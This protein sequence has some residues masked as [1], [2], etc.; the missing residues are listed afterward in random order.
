MDH[1]VWNILYADNQDL[2]FFPIVLWTK[3]SLVIFTKSSPSWFRCLEVGS[4]RKSIDFVNFLTRLSTRYFQLLYLSPELDNVGAAFFIIPGILNKNSC[5][6]HFGTVWGAASRWIVIS[7][8][9]SRLSNDS[10]GEWGIE[11]S[12]VWK[13]KWC[14]TAPALQWFLNKGGASWGICRGPEPSGQASLTET[15]RSSRPWYGSKGLLSRK[16]TSGLSSGRGAR[17]DAEVLS[18]WRFFLVMVDF[19]GVRLLSGSGWSL[20]RVY[21]HTNKTHL[22]V[23]LYRWVYI[24]EADTK[25]LTEINEIRER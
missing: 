17:M 20:L 4:F 16:K 25:E 24:D 13:Y 15:S 23:I 6:C 22:K 12:K 8:T 5:S 11:E 21:I 14:E 19:L 9:K 18:S 10:G 7:T 2:I 3:C 1:T